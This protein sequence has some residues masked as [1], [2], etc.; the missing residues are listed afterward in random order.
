MKLRIGWLVIVAIFIGIGI[1]VFTFFN[2]GEK[3]TSHLDREFTMKI[4]DLA[5]VEE[6][7][8]KYEKV[9]D[10]R[11]KGNDCDKNGEKVAK[12]IVIKNP[13]IEY[14]EIGSILEEEVYLN[15]SDY[16]LKLVNFNE[17]TDE[18]T[19]KVLEKNN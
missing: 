14:I 9:I 10:N 17:E 16:K 2:S 18:I 15:K 6:L 4:G 5:T 7:K 8:I 3:I 13:Y 19:L 11:C 1:W 12:L